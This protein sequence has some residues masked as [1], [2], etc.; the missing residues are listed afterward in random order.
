MIEMAKESKVDAVYNF[1]MNEFAQYHYQE[2]DRLIISQLAKCCNTSEIP[3]R[4]A[5]R[6]LESEGYLKIDKNRGATVTGFSK[7][8]LQNIAQVKGVLEGYATRL[9]VDYMTPNDIRELYEINEK[10]RSASQEQN[11][12][13]YS[14]M[15]RRFHSEIYKHV[16]NPEL[17]DLIERLTNRWYFTA[18]V[19]S[20][21]P[22][23]MTSSYQEHSIILSLIEARKYDELENYVR[24]HKINALSAWRSGIKD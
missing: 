24:K 9:A 1:I 11:D 16:P 6:R 15:N 23:R 20:M 5:L 17:R 10:M 12:V 7:S 18:S 3:V 2:G 4:E 14:E 21:V 19:F 22:E 8:V 13:I